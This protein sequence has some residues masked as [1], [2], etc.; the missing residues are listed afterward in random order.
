MATTPTP[1][2]Y[3]EDNPDHAELFLRCWKGHG[4]APALVHLEDGES[5][6]NY[7]ARAERDEVLKPGLVLLDLRLPKVDG[8]EVLARFKASPQIGAV[9]VV[10]LSTSANVTDVARAYANHAN[11]Y[12]VKPED[13]GQLNAL[14]HDLGAWWCTWNVLAANS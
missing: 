4:M 13:F 11:S 6:L 10:I 12:V 8:F 14:V 7:L 1:V 2:L 9:P 3:V 5:A